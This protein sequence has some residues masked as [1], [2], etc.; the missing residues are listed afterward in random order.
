MNFL[1]CSENSHIIPNFF[2]WFIEEFPSQSRISL[3]IFQP[4]LVTGTNF[5][6][7]RLVVELLLRGFEGQKM[8]EQWWLNQENARKM[9]LEL[10]KC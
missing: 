3:S 4:H 6:G 2:L 10:P 1:I 5:Q 7:Q 8:V 9:V